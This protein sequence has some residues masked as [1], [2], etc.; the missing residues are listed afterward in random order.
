M[1]TTV[2]YQTLGPQGASSCG[3]T[4]RLAV[5]VSSLPTNAATVTAPST[6]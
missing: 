5:A 6:S 3:A 4:G 2:V 1:S